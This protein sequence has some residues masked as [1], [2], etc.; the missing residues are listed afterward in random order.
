LQV[1]VGAIRSRRVTL[2]VQE[3]EVEPPSPMTNDTW[4]M[5]K[6]LQLKVFGVTD[7]NTM[8]PQLSEPLR[9]TSAGAMVAVPAAERL[10]VAGLQVTVG[11]VLSLML[12]VVWHWL[13]LPLMSVTVRVAGCGMPTALQLKVLGDKVMLCKPQGAVLLKSA[14]EAGMVMVLP[15]MSVKTTRQLAVGGAQQEVTVTRAVALYGQAVG[16]LVENP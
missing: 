5:P 15:V 4:L 12:I 11:G 16:G 3:A 10:I 6:L 14:A 9:N 13:L 7:C 8:L 1:M 2:A